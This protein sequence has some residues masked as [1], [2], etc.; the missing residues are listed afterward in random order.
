MPTLEA[1]LPAPRLRIKVMEYEE[2]GIPL[3]VRGFHKLPGWEDA[4]FTPEWL[5]EHSTGLNETISV[6][7]VYDKRDSEMPLPEF[8]ERCKNI[9]DIVPGGTQKERYYGKDG[10]CPE[11]WEAW[12]S[13]SGVVPKQILPF[14]GDDAFRFIPKQCRAETLMTYFGVG[15]TGTPCHKD[16]CASVGQNLMVHTENEGSAVWY[17]TL[18]EDA[19]SVSQYF[20][21]L[22]QEVDLETH[23][24]SELELKVA[25]FKVY[26]HRQERGDLICVP[27][28][29][30]HQVINEGGISIK[31]SWSRMILSSLVMA[32]ES[33]LPIYHRVC[34]P[35]IYSVKHLIH[36]AVMS[37][38]KSLSEALSESDGDVTSRVCAM[39]DRLKPLVNAYTEIIVEGWDPQRKGEP[40]TWDPDGQTRIS[41]DFCGAEIFQSYFECRECDQEKKESV[42]ICS[43][44][45]VEGRSC[46]CDFMEPVTVQPFSLLLSV[47]N[48]AV[49]V[50][51]RCLTE[52]EQLI[53]DY[54]HA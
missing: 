32:Y 9:T 5:L 53:P 1:S 15:G 16:L 35:E 8:I 26:M 50:L 37:G 28:K 30:C 3:V 43:T 14:S 45:Y 10:I 31:L 51:N 4:L 40:Q 34:R 23:V 44:C 25:P 48:K 12:L 17:M 42:S 52:E 11:Q 6:R 2:K 39:R 13:S 22:G 36:G 20:R 46:V 7:N 27:Q 41:C 18:R 38:T 33:E 29:S 24:A 19:T 49:D 21:S 47:R 54:T